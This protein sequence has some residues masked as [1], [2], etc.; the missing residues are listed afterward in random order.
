MAQCT[1][2]VFT[3]LVEFVK[4]SP[5][6]REVDNGPVAL[7]C[8]GGCGFKLLGRW[9]ICYIFNLEVL[10]ARNTSSAMN[11]DFKSFSRVS[12]YSPATSIRPTRQST[13]VGARCSLGESSIHLSLSTRFKQFMVMK[14]T[15]LRITKHAAVAFAMPGSDSL[16]KRYGELSTS[17][18]KVNPNTPML[19]IS[20]R[21]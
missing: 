2:S 3:V 17:R 18:A 14:V 8:V 21:L 16:P 15:T 19:A 12:A 10:P 20:P 9:F 1:V 6:S 5:T 13:S 11:A 7:T 4:C